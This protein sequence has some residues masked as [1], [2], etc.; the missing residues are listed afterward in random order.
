LIWIYCLII[1]AMVITLA[2]IDLRTM[3]LPNYL[4]L[5]LMILGLLVS[6]FT[7]FGF[8]QAHE[9]IIGLI[10]GYSLIW[11]VN[12]FYFLVTKKHGIGM[13]DAKLLSAFG[14]ILGYF[15]ILPILLIASVLGLLGGILWL[16]LNK[17]SHQHAFPFGPYLCI[18]GLIA[19][20]DIV[21]NTFFIR[22][23]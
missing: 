22:N 2:L 18:A 1:T 20:F 19:I 13:G 23:F 4:T 6:S 17:L 10:L 8:C 15:Y 5:P 3:Q 12:F 16:K 21:S 14:S 7:N 9:S 11:G